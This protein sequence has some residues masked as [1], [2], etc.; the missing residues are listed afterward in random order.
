MT[1][2]NQL[3]I[4]V[5]SAEEAAVALEAG[6]DLIDVKEPSAGPLGVAHHEVLAA[7]L[8][9]AKGTVPV[10][11]AL[12]EWT[13]D[14]IN[15]AHW[16]LQLPVQFLKWGL[17]GYGNN[18]GWGED[19]LETRRQIRTGTEVVL[20][21][22]ADWEKAK[23]PPP[24]AVVQFA[25]RFRYKAVL[26]DTFAKDSGTLLDALPLAELTELVG[27]LK[28]SRVPVALG[29]SLKIEQLKQLKL[30]EPEWFAV[31]GAVCAGGTRTGTLDPVRIQK[32]KAAL[33]G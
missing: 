13:P 17:A 15:A 16:H 21:A 28:K 12:G 7:V 33:A 5:R 14:A 30:L 1:T 3:L 24:A 23:S 20:V 26:F 19:L 10:S 6:A 32:W 25:K 9:V 2:T 27:S 22:Y 18:P 4:S 11:A 8:A 29:G 31:R